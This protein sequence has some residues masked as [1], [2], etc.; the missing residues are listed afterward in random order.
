[1]SKRLLH[2]ILFLFFAL[3]VFAQRGVVVAGQIVDKGDKEPI[4][5]VVVYFEKSNIATTTNDEGFFLLQSQYPQEKIIV[6]IIG[7][8]SQQIKVK[9]GQNLGLT[10]E[11]VEDQNQ[12]PEFVVLGPNTKRLME[13]ARENRK[14]NNYDNIKNYVPVVAAESKASLKQLSKK[15]VNNRMFGELRRNMIMAQQDTSL[16][17]PIYMSNETY[18]IKDKEKIQLT[19]EQKSIVP[20]HSKAIAELITK[21]PSELNFYDSYLLLFGKNFLSPLANSSDSYYRFTISDSTNTEYGKEYTVRFRPQ[22]DKNLLFKGEMVIDSA[23]CSLKR[24]SA[25]ILPSANLNFIEEFLIEQVFIPHPE[26][27]K[28]VLESQQLVIG[29][30]LTSQS[31]KKSSNSFFVTR[32]LSLADSKGKELPKPLPFKA[33]LYSS[34]FSTTL[35]NLGK[36]KTSQIFNQISNVLMNDYL[37]LGYVDWGPL[38]IT[39]GTNKAEGAHLTLSGRTSKKVFENFTIGPVISY[40]F[41]DETWKFGGE[42]Q[43]RLKKENYEVIGIRFDDNYYQTDFDFHDELNYENSVSNGIADITSFLFTEFSSMYSRR[44]IGKIF[45]NRQWINDFNTQSILSATK[46]IP[47]DYVE[48]HSGDTYYS[49]IKDYRL[50]LDFRYAHKEHFIDN[51][52][53]R[54]FINNHRPVIHFAIEGGKYFM[55][56][57]SD[58]YLKLHFT[59]KHTIMLGTVGK[60]NYSV[61]AGYIFG[62]VPF[63]LLEIYS[64]IE[65]YG[66]QE[67]NYYMSSTQQ[68]ASD[69]YANLESQFITNGFIFNNIPLIK[70]L[71]LREILSLK[72]A[73]GRLSDKQLNFTDLPSYIKPLEEP[74]LWIGAGICNLFKVLAIEYIMEMPRISQPKDISWNLRARIFIDF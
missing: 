64:G 50:T 10:I 12:L 6:S 37:N 72:L 33:E 39:S 61:Q 30:Q 4:P 65:N 9:S 69:I 67:F 74:Y 42:A 58:Y 34:D 60:L 38:L 28:W 55:D 11:L 36:T 52:F 44:Q 23:S 27:E 62:E 17:L 5:G 2:S 25:M 43:Y 49:S 56:D 8:K 32:S 26:S 1:M 18:Q 48:Y 59:E 54:I 20:E 13:R 57:Y 63:P 53:H 45:Y 46:Y 31:D 70:K 66:M 51:F 24:M 19:F 7:Y 29:A 71:N 14:E 73:T 21:F 35:D 15:I 22:N 47:N 16:L 41:G 40:G 3:S 68:Y